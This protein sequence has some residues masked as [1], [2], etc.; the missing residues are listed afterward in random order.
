MWGG[1]IRHIYIPKLSKF[2]HE[3]IKL[4]NDI[5]LLTLLCY[6]CDDYALIHVIRSFN[7]SQ[8]NQ[9]QIEEKRCTKA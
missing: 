1:D 9:S 6:M 8:G 4:K 2:A 3:L 7:N 5:Y